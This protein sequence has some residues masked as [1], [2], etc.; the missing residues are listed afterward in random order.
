MAH[1]LEK[2]FAKPFLARANSALLLG[3]VCGGLA[4]CAFGAVVLDLSRLF[5][6]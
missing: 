2:Q 4:I 3:L 5:M 1:P 6:E